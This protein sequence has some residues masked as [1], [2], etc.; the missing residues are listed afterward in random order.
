MAGFLRRENPRVEENSILFKALKDSNLPK[1][2]KDD[3]V[4]FQVW[5]FLYHLNCNSKYLHSLKFRIY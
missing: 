4:L 2:L 3:A 1:F 5:N